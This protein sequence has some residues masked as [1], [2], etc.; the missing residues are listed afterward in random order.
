[1]TVAATAT[2]P[3]SA[4]QRAGK[5]RAKATAAPKAAKY[6]S[7]RLASTQELAGC[8]DQEIEANVRAASAAN[9]ARVTAP[10]AGPDAP[11]RTTA[12]VSAAATAMSAISTQV[13]GARATPPAARKAISSRPA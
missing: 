4:G 10:Q 1:M 3:T 9:S 8:T 11:S 12:T 6:E 2:A 5:S 13:L 7:V